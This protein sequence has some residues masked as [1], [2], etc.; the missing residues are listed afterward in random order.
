MDYYSI[1]GRLSAAQAD[2]A[3]VQTWKTAVTASSAAVLS[4]SADIMDSM[5]QPAYSSMV[6]YVTALCAS[7]DPLDGYFLY[8]NGDGPLLHIQDKAGT[9]LSGFGKYT[10]FDHNVT[11]WQLSTLSTGAPQFAT[12]PLDWNNTQSHPLLLSAQHFQFGM[13]Y[14]YQEADTASAILGLDQQVTY[15]ENSV[16]TI[17]AM[18]TFYTETSSYFSYY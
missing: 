4:L 17:D 2:I 12:S 13:K 16:D 15:A 10:S 11:A 3:R 1:A 9:A 14:Y 18:I 7:Q 5:L 6:S 8:W